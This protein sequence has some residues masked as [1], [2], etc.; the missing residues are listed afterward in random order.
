MINTLVKKARVL[1][2]YFNYRLTIANQLQYTYHVITFSPKHKRLHIERKI[3]GHRVFPM[4][5]A[6][7]A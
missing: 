4:G 6:Y 7:Y 2:F 5:F 3:T 1:S